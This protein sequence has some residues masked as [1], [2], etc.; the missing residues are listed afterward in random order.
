MEWKDVSAI[1]GKSAPLLGGLLGGPAGTAIGGIVASALGSEGTPDAVR[2]AIATDPNAAVKLAQIEADQKVKLQ[3]L[4]TKQA[5]VL[6]DAMTQ[7]TAAVNQ[8]IQVEAHAEHWPTYSWRPM[9]GLA[10]ALA[11]VLTVLTVFLAYGEAVMFGRSEALAQ[12]PG[13][14][15][16]V[17]GIIAVVSPILG[18]A[19]WFRGKM[20][21]SQ[22]AN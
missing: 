21:L 18:I 14:L 7:T 4:S 15:A 12:L 22:V 10:V 6:I 20:Q 19:S 1:V 16:A 9:I 3:E 11:V 13:V 5:G 2:Q 8:T 17:A